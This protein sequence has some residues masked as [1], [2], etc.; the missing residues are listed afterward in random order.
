[1]VPCHAAPRVGAL[2]PCQCP[3]SLEAAA[4]GGACSSAGSCRGGRAES[5]D[6][7][8][9]ALCAAHGGQSGRDGLWAM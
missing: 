2:A 9:L 5:W 6:G 7:G 8:Q 4:S 3:L 1:M